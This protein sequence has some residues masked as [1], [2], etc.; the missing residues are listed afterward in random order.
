MSHDASA[1]SILHDGKN[2]HVTNQGPVFFF[3]TCTWDLTIF[4]ARIAAGSLSEDRSSGAIILKPRTKRGEGR[5]T[6]SS[7]TSKIKRDRAVVAVGRGE[8]QIIDPI[9]GR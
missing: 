5:S 3:L 4:T 8:P 9:A 2:V 7:K 6:S 1:W